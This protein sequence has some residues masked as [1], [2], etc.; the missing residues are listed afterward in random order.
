MKSSSVISVVA[1]TVATATLA[2]GGQTGCG[3]EEP[4][5]TLLD[6]GGTSG[7]G[8]AGYPIGQSS[9]LGIAC[10][11]DADCAAESGLTCITSTSAA[12]D[13]GSPAHGI[14]T[15][16]CGQPGEFA[17]KAIDGD[18]ACVPF[19]QSTAYCMPGCRFGS[20]G[21]GEDKCR[22]RADLACVGV[23]DFELYTNVCQTDAECADGYVCSGA[24]VRLTSACMP[25]C[26]GDADCETGQF[27]D[28]QFG[29][30]GLCRG[31]PPSGLPTGAPCDPTARPDGCRGVCVGFSETIGICTDGCTVGANATCGWTG[32]GP[33]D[34]MCVVAWQGDGTGDG[35]FCR[36]F[37][38]CNGECTNS[39]LLC[40]AFPVGAAEST[41]YGRRGYC[42]VP[43]AAGAGGSSGLSCAGG[44][45][46][47][48]GAG[49]S[50][51]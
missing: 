24:C 34:A 51:G 44:A 14:C 16:P 25:Q 36:P 47:G 29:Y 12:L 27:C 18:A 23:P 1:L 7:A 8:G 22:G 43:P 30:A 20:P 10:A 33:A 40:R 19:S 21:I 28:F 5:G 4:G 45:P 38:D 17:C 41:R 32:S 9:V 37:C 13:S 11:S 6:G 42:T 3:N 15:A 48:G 31:N 39:E 35:G 50:G 2:L 46:S 26:N 49:G